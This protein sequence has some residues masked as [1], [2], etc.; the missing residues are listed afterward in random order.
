VAVDVA[1]ERERL[2]RAL[3]G[4]SSALSLPRLAELLGAGSVI[5]RL[6][7]FTPVGEYPDDAVVVA[8]CPTDEERRPIAALI[9]PLYDARRIVDAA[10]RRPGRPLSSGEEGTFLYALDRAGGD[11]LAAGGAGFRISGLLAGPDQ[12]PD[13]LDAPPCH[14][15]EI[16]IAIDGATARAEI[17][18]AS[19]PAPQRAARCRGGVERASGWPA[20][21]R[22]VIGAA[23]IPA[24]AA[25]ALAA[26]DVVEL[27]RCGHPA[28]TGGDRG[29]SLA[30]GGVRFGT[31]W[32]DDRR[33]ELVSPLP[34][35][36]AMTTE[37][38]AA[39][40]DARLEP[41]VD[42]AAMEVVAQVEIGRLA[43][44]V[45]QALALV[46]GRILALD[47]DVGAEVWIRVG[48][49]LIARGELVNC[50]G[51]LAVEVTEVP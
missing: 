6:A 17:V 47:R 42:G 18:W 20:R 34:R 45:E 36:S 7:R 11:W 37:D 4:P 8:L 39:P 1:V 21:F 2:A 38:E 9:V 10:L 16:E 41:A 35:R 44:T 14:A 51:R 15:L 24:A 12:I 29:C 3:A 50:G 5:A 22:L 40:I 46:P 26:G 30:C 23:R 32:L 25:V 49:K 48:D 31:R 19:L 33:L 43:L 28:A 27:D 13:L